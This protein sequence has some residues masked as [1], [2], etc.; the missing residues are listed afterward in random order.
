MSIIYVWDERWPGS[1]EFARKH[2]IA[3]EPSFGFTAHK[4]SRI[5]WILSQIIGLSQG[6]GEIKLLRICA[7]GNMGYVQLGK[8]GLTVATAAHMSVL[9]HFFSKDP[10]T[11]IEIHACG[12]ASATNIVK[13][14]AGQPVRDARGHL[15][16]E[17]GFIDLWEPRGSGMLLLDAIRKATGTTVLAGIDCQNPDEDYAFEGPVVHAVSP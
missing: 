3:G 13:S 1:F 4:S 8:D 17:P 6:P 5:G 16:C 14:R 10:A 11:R 7:H 15:V 9:K 12:V 2:A